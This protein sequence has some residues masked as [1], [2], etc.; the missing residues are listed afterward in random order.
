[1]DHPF[2][3]PGRL[4]LNAFLPRLQYGKVQPAVEWSARDE[5][6]QFFDDG[7]LFVHDCSC[8]RAPS[9]THRRRRSLSILLVPAS[10]NCL[11]KNT[12]LGCWYAGPLARANSRISSSVAC[13]PCRSTM[14]AYGTCPFIS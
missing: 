12:R 11:R 3:A 1:M 8:R 2:L 10:G 4:D 9:A 14:N 5:L 6:L 13:A 7:L